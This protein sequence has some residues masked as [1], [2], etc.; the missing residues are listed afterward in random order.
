VAV[1]HGFAVINFSGSVG[2]TTVARQLLLPRLPQGTRLINVESVNEGSG[3]AHTLRGHHF[4]DLQEFLQ[5][6]D[7]AV[8]DISASSVEDLLGL[9]RSFQ[10]RRL[11]SGR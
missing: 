4:G 3:Q 5:T 9:M 2:M 1:R 7:H 6:V 8:V 10:G 11:R